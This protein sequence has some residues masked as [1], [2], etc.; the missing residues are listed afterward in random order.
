MI[1]FRAPHTGGGVTYRR[2]CVVICYTAAEEVRYEREK[3]TSSGSRCCKLRF[4]SL[5]C[6]QS[7]SIATIFSTIRLLRLLVNSI[8]GNPIVL[9]RL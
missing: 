3:M 5:A 6:K 9:L 7:F 2:R 8:I 4:L 1:M